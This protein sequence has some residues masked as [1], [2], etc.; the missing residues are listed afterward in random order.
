MYRDFYATMAQVLPLLL[1]ALMWDSGYLHR[2]RHQR[3]PP[4]RLDPRGVR[5]WTK[6]RVRAYSLFVTGALVGGTGATVLV[7]AGLVPDSVPL[8]AALGVAALFALGTLAVRISVDVI[9]ATAPDLVG[10]A[11]TT[12]DPAKGGPTS[13]PPA[14]D[15]PGEPTRPVGDL[16]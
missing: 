3:R 15:G 4:R 6:P 7:L 16:G 14:D 2:L 5:F 9:A 8:R 11:S 1:L 10:G 12:P 13:P